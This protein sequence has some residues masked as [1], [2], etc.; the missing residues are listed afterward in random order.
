MAHNHHY[1]GCCS[2]D[3]LLATSMLRP[4]NFCKPFTSIKSLGFAPHDFMHLP[5]VDMMN[6]VILPAVLSHE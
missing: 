1:A 3:C 4:H 5:P 2:N 6:I